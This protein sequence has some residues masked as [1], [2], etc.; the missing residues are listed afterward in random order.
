MASQD[1]SST[2]IGPVGRLENPLRFGPDNRPV[3]VVPESFR[4]CETFEA[5]VLADRHDVANAV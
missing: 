5:S 1:V 3:A 4:N 2:N